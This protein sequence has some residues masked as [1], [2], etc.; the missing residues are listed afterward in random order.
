MKKILLLAALFIGFSGSVLQ[1]SATNVTSDFF[2]G[3]ELFFDMSF[4]NQEKVPCIYGSDTS[5]FTNACAVLHGETSFFDTGKRNTR[6][7]SIDWYAINSPTELRSAATMGLHIHP[8]LSAYDDYISGTLSFDEVLID[9]VALMK[10]GIRNTSWIVNPEFIMQGDSK[11]G[12]GYF[13]I[14]Y[15]D[16]RTAGTVNYGIITKDE[17]KGTMAFLNYVIEYSDLGMYN[18]TSEWRKFLVEKGLNADLPADQKIFEEYVD[19]RLLQNVSVIGYVDGL[20]NAVSRKRSLDFN[21]VPSNHI[22][23]SGILYIKSEGIVEG[24]A[25]GSFRPDSPINRAEFT[26]ILVAANVKENLSNWQTDS[27]AKCFSD[28]TK[29]E[30]YTSYV[31]LAKSKGI[32]SGNPDGTFRPANNINLAEALKIVM[33]QYA[34]KTEAITGEPWYEEYMRAAR[35]KRFLITIPDDPAHIVTRGEMADIILQAT[36][37][38]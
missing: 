35:E 13:Y 8:I 36:Y 14:S 24:Y 5:Y 22:H 10:P 9:Q 4:Y 18:S 37:P 1:A 21:D 20:K 31:C 6:S 38:Q 29:S 25:D 7:F 32:I 3:T 15:D 28:F 17:E 16:G 11:I 34:I 27:A 12:I 19:T 23:D 33:K 26:K 2:R 30:W